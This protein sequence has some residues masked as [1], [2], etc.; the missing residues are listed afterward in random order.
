MNL[1]EFSGVT[2]P[3]KVGS[4]HAG[5][6]RCDLFPEDTPEG[7]HIG[8]IDGLL[9]EMVI[10]ALILSGKDGIVEYANHAFCGSFTPNKTADAEASDCGLFSLFPE[11]R[12]SE[13]PKLLEV[14]LKERRTVYEP[15]VFLRSQNAEGE[16]VGN[17]YDCQVVFCDLRLNE[18]PSYVLFLIKR[19]EDVV[20]RLYQAVLETVITAI[21][22]VGVFRWDVLDN[23]F[24]TSS[25][26]NRIL[27]LDKSIGTLS[28]DD[29]LR[30]VLTED[31]EMVKD[32]FLKSCDVCG[33]LVVQFRLQSPLEENFWGLLKGDRKHGG[34]LGHGRYLACAIA[35][36]KEKL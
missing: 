3:A 11:F 8:K 21:S 16:P 20:K 9:R 7:C 19:T 10:P 26:F 29:F 5:G 13:L 1:L 31:R 4:C 17:F 32:A 6:A 22:G 2:L 25:N 15:D 34:I 24:R 18:E 35:L 36:S 30:L 28:F 27:G 23:V 12:Q 33:D 14:S